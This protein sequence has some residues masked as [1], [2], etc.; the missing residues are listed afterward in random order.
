VSSVPGPPRRFGGRGA[1][2]LERDEDR[3]TRQRGPSDDERSQLERPVR[4][5]AVVTAVWAAVLL[6]ANL[7][8]GRPAG[9]SLLATVVAAAVFAAVWHLVVSDRKARRY[10]RWRTRFEHRS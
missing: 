5:T 10:R 2:K 1:P 4:S 9:E 3:W 6:V 8:L 7:A